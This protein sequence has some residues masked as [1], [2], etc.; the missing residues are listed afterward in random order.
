MS[1][2]CFSK[3]P[4]HIPPDGECHLEMKNLI[5][6]KYLEVHRALS[7]LWS[8]STY[9]IAKAVLLNSVLCPKWSQK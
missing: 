1:N 2:A 6:V 3:T 8:Y 4:K 7:N 9:D 5:V